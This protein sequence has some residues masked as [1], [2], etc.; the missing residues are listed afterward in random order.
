LPPAEA[1]YSGPDDIAGIQTGPIDVRI[2]KPQVSAIAARVDDLIIRPGGEL[3]H[4]DWGMYEAGIGGP[5]NLLVR[6]GWPSHL[7]G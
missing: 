7:V 6:A 2:R 1:G 4:R 5:D 3:G